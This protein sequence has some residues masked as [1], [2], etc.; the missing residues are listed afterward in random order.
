MQTKSIKKCS[1]PLLEEKSETLDLQPQTPSITTTQPAKE[2]NKT[3]K[4]TKSQNYDKGLI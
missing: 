4:L 2:I 1:N 3:P